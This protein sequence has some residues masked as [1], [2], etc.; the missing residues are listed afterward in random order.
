M[1]NRAS[2]LPEDTASLVELTKYLTHCQE[3]KMFELRKMIRTSANNLMFLVS[4]AIF[5]GNNV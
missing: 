2:E 4:H 3:I 5:P 1:S